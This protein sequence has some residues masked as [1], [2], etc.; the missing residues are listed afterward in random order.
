[1]KQW[2]E[3]W[4]NSGNGKTIN[5]SYLYATLKWMGDKWVVVDLFW[6]E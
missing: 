3:F 2:R 6:N 4:L 5:N 1:M